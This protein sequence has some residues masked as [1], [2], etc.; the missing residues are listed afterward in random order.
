MNTLI[1]FFAVRPVFTFE[2]IRIV[3][4]FYLLH[5]VVQLYVSLAEVSAVMARNGISWEI[6]LPRMAPLILGA[7]AQI[8]LVRLLV[9]VAASVLLTP[10]RSDT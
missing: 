6:W 5:M 8:A 9:E 10:R 3:W 4:Y 7:A 1:N 2:G